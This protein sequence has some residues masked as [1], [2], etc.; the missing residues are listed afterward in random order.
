MKRPFLLTT[1]LTIMLLLIF[2]TPCHA[3]DPDMI[4]IRYMEGNVILA[5][6]G[7]NDWMEAAVNTP[8]IEGDTIKTGPAGRIELF[9]KDGS[10]IRIGKNS[11]AKVMAVESKAVELKLDTG[12]AYVISRGSNG[13]PI[14]LDT[15]LAGLDMASPA[16]TRIDVYAGGPTEVSVYA[17]NIFAAQ[18]SGRML[19]NA[20]QR[21]VMKGDGSTPVIGSLRA[22]DDWYAWNTARDRAFS[23]TATDESYAYLPDELR[24]YSTDLNANGQ[25]IYTPEY[26]YVWTPT[27]ITV[28]TWS[29]YRFG[30][31][32]WIRGNYVWVGYDP[33]GWAPY[34]YGRWIHHDRA[35][36]CWVPPKRGHV[37]WEPAHVAWVHSSQKIGWVP[38]APGERYDRRSAPVINQTN[39]YNTYKNVTIERSLLGVAPAHRNAAIA[40]SL[41]VTERNVMLHQKRTP[42]NITRPGSVPLKTIGLAPGITPA[43]AKN[44][45]PD[46][47]KPLRTIQ[48]VP[49]M[50]SAAPRQPA[51][52]SGTPA[53]ANPG[54]GIGQVHARPINQRIDSARTGADRVPERASAAPQPDRRGP[55][56]VPAASSS[57]EQSPARQAPAVNVRTIGNKAPSDPVQRSATPGDRQAR[58]EKPRANPGTPAERPAPAVAS[59]RQGN[60]PSG[61]AR[62]ESPRSVQRSAGNNPAGQPARASTGPGTGNAMKTRTAPPPAVPDSRVNKPPVNSA[63]PQVSAHTAGKP[64]PDRENGSREG[65]PSQSPKDANRKL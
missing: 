23:A 39:I 15:P 26:E 9:L 21:L 27:V 10:L 53:P 60:T 16:T 42:V 51:A 20:G 64:D 62:Q 46:Q 28:G 57:R 30:R 45:L 8:L 61:W 59:V 47:K 18:Q 41:V 1:C 43:H 25:W 7:S 44:G 56:S 38:L 2:I 32:A 6:S 63:G 22:A 13:V 34:H 65:R 19:V 24:S 55:L 12:M 3:A 14:F 37:Q 48:S 35:G 4:Y 5:E 36:W 52:S 11:I 17:G 49:A 58:L 29:P 40:N 33:W 31:W 50:D 54:Q